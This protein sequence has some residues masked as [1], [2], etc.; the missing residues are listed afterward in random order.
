M[1]A[2]LCLLQPCLAM[3]SMYLLN[4][5]GSIETDTYYVGI[6]Y[7]GNT[8]QHHRV[9]VRRA[10]HERERNRTRERA[11]LALQQVVEATEQ[12]LPPPAQRL[13]SPACPHIFLSPSICKAAQIDPMITVAVHESCR[14]CK[15]MGGY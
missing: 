9:A 13:R 4:A 8:G 1:V 6:S 7:A 11:L 2:L 10:R 14:R 15:V 5:Q 12:P 3:A